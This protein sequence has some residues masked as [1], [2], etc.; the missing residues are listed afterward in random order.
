MSIRNSDQQEKRVIILTSD[1]GFGH[2]SASNAI[3]AALEEVSQGKCQI[4]IVNPLEDKRLPFF[5]RESQEDYDKIVREMPKL[6][7]LGFDATDASVAAAL[8]ESGATVLFY[9]IMDDILKKYQPHTIITTYPLYQ[10]PLTSIFTIRRI[11]IPLITV[12]TD[13]ITVHRFWF[14]KHTDAFIVPTEPVKQLALEYGV[15]PNKI[16]LIGIPVHPNIEK[17]KRS[18]E[19]LREALGWQTDLPTILAVG[20]KRV[21]GLIESLN[22]VNHFG[23]RLQLIVVAGGDENLY[24]KLQQVKWH[25]PTH[26]YNY[27]SDMP[28]F[29]RAADALITKA[30]GLISTEALAAGLPIILI[31]LL[32]GQET[33]N[34]EYIV[35]NNAGDMATTPVELLEVLFHWLDN[36]QQLMR[37]RAANAARI[38]KPLAAHDIS[39]IAWQL[40]QIGPTRKNPLLF[41]R[42]P[43]V[44]DFLNNNKVPWNKEEKS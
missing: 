18:R 5:I 4:D 9:E 40:A 43:K 27:V 33:G 25:I 42:R 24:Q 15:D 32:P 34:A 20:S 38:G 16:H 23:S 6:Y 14:H 30:G 7:Q 13:L 17:E 1:A 39:V 21:E 41:A 29:L 12:V 2:R 3:K 11:A 8:F 19:E 36:G 26:I 10:A 31:D 28:M 35:K 22:I 37:E 44:V